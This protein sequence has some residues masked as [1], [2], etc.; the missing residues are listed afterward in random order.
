M[1]AEEQLILEGSEK[2][3]ELAQDGAEVDGEAIAAARALSVR[4]LRK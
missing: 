3:D 4:Q 2:A 1:T